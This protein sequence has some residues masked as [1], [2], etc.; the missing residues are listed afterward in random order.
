MSQRRKFKNNP[1]VTEYGN[2]EQII[3]Y[4]LIL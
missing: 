4:L 1:E 3:F 2:K